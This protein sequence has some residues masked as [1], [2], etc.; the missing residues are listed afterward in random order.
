MASKQ[1]AGFRFSACGRMCQ[2]VAGH[3]AP[4][5]TMVSAQGMADGQMK[6]RSNGGD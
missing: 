6:A 5:T 2:R 4:Q 3:D 1:F